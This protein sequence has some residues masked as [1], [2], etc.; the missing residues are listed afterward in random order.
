MNSTAF[1]SILAK[2]LDEYK[3]VNFDSAGS[4]R[5]YNDDYDESILFARFQGNLSEIVSQALEDP[6][7]MQA[8]ESSLLQNRHWIT[9]GDI[10]GHSFTLTISGMNAR[11]NFYACRNHA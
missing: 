10:C 7:I 6:F 4:I 11:T 9:S 3:N 2:A 5:V 8:V 1:L